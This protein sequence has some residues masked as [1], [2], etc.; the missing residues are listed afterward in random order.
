[1][2][3]LVAFLMGVIFT[4]SFNI[5]TSTVLEPWQYETF[6]RVQLGIPLLPSLFQL[7]FIGVGYIPE[8]PHSLIIKNRKESAREVLNLFYEDSYVDQMVEDRESAIFNKKAD[9]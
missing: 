9:L 8:S 4:D 2:G 6:W 7:L 1:L 5:K 3:V